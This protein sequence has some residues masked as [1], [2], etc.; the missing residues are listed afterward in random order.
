MVNHAEKLGGP[1]TGT[2]D[3]RVTSL[4]SFLRKTKLDELPQL[5][6]V[7]IGDMSLVGPRPEV[8][9]YVDKYKGEEK[10]ILSV[11]PG[12]TDLSSIQ[13]INLDDLV[14]DEDPDQYFIEH[15]LPIKNA[16]RVKYVNEATFLGDLRILWKTFLTIL[17]KVF[18]G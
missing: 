17:P 18:R 11:R 16:L 9:E 8:M 2:K 5:M 10:S 13:F 4:G 12:I 6:N 14:G 15:I 7:L 1:T 3:P